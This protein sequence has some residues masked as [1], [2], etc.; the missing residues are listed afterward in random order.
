MDP[1]TASVPVNAHGWGIALLA[2]TGLALGA[3]CSR[4]AE[5]A[6]APT[7]PAASAAAGSSTARIE[8]ALPAFLAARGRTS[9]PACSALVTQAREAQNAGDE[10]RADALLDQQLAAHPDDLEA[11][12]MRSVLHYQRIEMGAARPGLERI[13]DAGPTFAGADFVFYYY[14]GCLMRLGDA[15]GARRALE[16]NLELSPGDGETYYLLGELELQLGDD[17]AALARYEQAIA[18]FE[19]PGVRNPAPAPSRA[20]AHTGVARALISSGQLERARAALERS[21]QIDPTESQNHYLM[22]RVLKQLGDKAGARKA[23]VDFKRLESGQK[24]RFFGRE[25][26]AADGDREQGG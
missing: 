13:L 26:T 15:V 14:G 23:M 6:P 16:A 8:R 1:S 7:P 3:A 10:Q 17:A 25:K 20:R 24:P 12:L 11:L 18:A 2:S 5:T 9:W 4:P 22:A 19:G 21:M